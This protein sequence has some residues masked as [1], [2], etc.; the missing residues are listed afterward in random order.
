M[1][2]ALS[3]TGPLAGAVAAAATAGIGFSNGGYT[4]AGGVNDPAGTVHKGEIV[5]SQ[6]DIRKFG[7]VA[8]V[9]ALRNGN[10][11]AGRSASGGSSSSSAASNG[12]PAPE[13][14]MTFNL[15]ED[16][17]RAGQVSRR[18]LGE[19]DVIDICVAN[20]RGERELHQ[21][22]QEKYGL[23]SQGT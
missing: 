21:V 1:A 12:V 2:T 17:S 6:S 4:G 3:I 13:R 10:V 20:I 16:A 9:E 19:Q 15:I 14:P 5:W 23:Q 22:Q 8:S 7:G 11:S 18:Q